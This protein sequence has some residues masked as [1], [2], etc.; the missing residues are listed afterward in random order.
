MSA[1]RAGAPQNAAAA[2]PAT[3]NFFIDTPK[4]ARKSVID[5]SSRACDYGLAMNRQFQ[6]NFAG[7]DPMA[8]YQAV[9][10]NQ[11]FLLFF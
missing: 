5:E 7:C 11:L 1:A 2:I 8:T 10:A 4:R 3:T 6:D 9:V